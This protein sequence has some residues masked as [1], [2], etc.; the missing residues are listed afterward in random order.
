[1]LMI[2]V[3]SLSAFAAPIGSSFGTPPLRMAPSPAP[4]PQPPATTQPVP[5]PGATPRGS[6]LNMSV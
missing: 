4:A 3:T 1:M 2:A 6:I 5:S